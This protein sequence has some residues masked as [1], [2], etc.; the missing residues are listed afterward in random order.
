MNLLLKPFVMKKVIWTLFATFT[1]IWTVFAILAA[2]LARWTSDAIAS[3][4]VARTTHYVATTT[5]GVTKRIASASGRVAAQINQSVSEAVGSTVVG[6]KPQPSAGS[7]DAAAA[8]AASTPAPTVLPPL[9]EWVNQWLGPEAAQSIKDWGVWAASAANAGKAAVADAAKAS[10]R[11]VPEALNKAANQAS[12]TAAGNAPMEFYPPVEVVDLQTVEKSD[13]K[14]AAGVPWLSTVVGW[15]VPIVWAIWGIGM[16]LGL[17]LTLVA[18]WGVTRFL[19]IE[20]P[21]LKLRET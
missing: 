13:E 3:D 1:L 17:L 14:A 11:T 19:K 10:A 9:P 5:E 18:H 15:L 20:T 21:D 6:E 7:N 8:P 2:G 16:I 4:L 12:T